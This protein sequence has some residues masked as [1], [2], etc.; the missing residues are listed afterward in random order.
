MF[1]SEWREF[2]SAPCLAGKETWW[3]LA[4]RFCWNSGRPWHASELVSFL[5]GLRIYQHPGM[6]VNTHRIKELTGICVLYAMWNVPQ[7]N[8]Y[9]TPTNFSFNISSWPKIPPPKKK[10]WMNIT[11]LNAHWTKECGRI[12]WCFACGQT[13]RRACCLRRAVSCGWNLCEVTM[14]V[15]AR[16]DPT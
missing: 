9:V 1:L 16:S 2:P 8:S 14:E 10:T 3:Q 15:P 4:S 7:L 13:L 11:F 12:D 5:V 6:C